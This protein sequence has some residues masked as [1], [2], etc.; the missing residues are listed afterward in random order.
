LEK[1]KDITTKPDLGAPT[2]AKDRA[3]YLNSLE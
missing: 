1:L 2:D 3:E